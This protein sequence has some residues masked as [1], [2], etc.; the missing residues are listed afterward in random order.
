MGKKLS[1]DPEFESLFPPLADE[2]FAALEESIL[3]EGCRHRLILWNGFIVDGHN[4]Y[5]ICMKHG[6]PFETTELER[7]DTRES[8]ISW[9][10]DNQLA[11]RNLPE[12]QRIEL[13]A[14]KGHLIAALAKKKKAA[15]T[16]QHTSLP[17]N[18]TEGSAIDTRNEIAKAAGVSTGT[19]SKFRKIKEQAAPE[20]IEKVRSGE[21]KIDVA[22]QVAS[23]PKEEQA[24]LA[25]AGKDAMKAA[26]KKMRQASKQKQ[27]AAREAKSEAKESIIDPKS[28]ATAPLADEDELARLRIENA[29][30]RNRVEELTA[31]RKNT[32]IEIQL[33]EAQAEVQRLTDVCA[34]LNSR[35]AILEKENDVQVQ[36]QEMQ[37]QKDCRQQP[38]DFNIED[39]VDDV[40]PEPVECAAVAQVA[41]APLSVLAHAGTD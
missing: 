26:A 22:A 11:R 38:L 9:M 12:Y 19:I 24:A 34:E 6:R 13:A 8:V 39:R 36:R 18:L 1:I 3:R 7:R 33:A 30:L 16:N 21:V 32:E 35:I 5:K 28:A 40:L 27:S 25:A 2:E 14:K 31:A 23:L 4:R 10:I 17:S 20:V 41:S 37:G 15:G 29:T